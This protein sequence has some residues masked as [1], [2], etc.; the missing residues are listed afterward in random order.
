MTDD[1]YEDGIVR[2]ARAAHGAGK[3]EGANASATVDNPLCGDRVTIE[4]TVADGRVSAL[5][6]TVKGCLLC[7]AAASMLGL[8]APGLTAA[9]VTTNIAALDGLLQH[10]AAPPA[11]AWPEVAQFAPV[12]RHK[13]RFDCVRL[14]MQAAAK[15]LSE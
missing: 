15:V 3:L 7:K 1:L 12:A 8:H 11:G 14:P 9:E 2:L 4:V 10:G 13:S 6:H 5:G